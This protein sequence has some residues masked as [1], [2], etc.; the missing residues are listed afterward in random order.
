MKIRYFPPPEPCFELSE[1]AP[2]ML[3]I[4]KLSS[5]VAEE[6]NVLSSG[7]AQII[8]RSVGRLFGINYLS[9]LLVNHYVRKLAHFM[10]YFILGILLMNA[11]NISGIKGLKSVLIVFVLGLIYAASDEFY[12]L[13]VP[14]RSGEFRDVMI[15]GAGMACGILSYLLILAAGKNAR[16]YLR[17]EKN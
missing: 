1:S 6:S 15:D 17:A 4:I 12:Q 16:K 3:L 14:G 7:L 5:Q 2:W 11:F 8:I 10:S 13:F 9:P